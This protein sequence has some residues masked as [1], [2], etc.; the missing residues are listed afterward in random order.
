MKLFNWRLY[1][2][3]LMVAVLSA[4]AVPLQSDADLTGDAF[5][6]VG[7]FAF[8]FTSS[9]QDPY[10]AQGGFKWQDTG[11]LLKLD[12]NNPMGSI[13]A[14]IEITDSRSVVQRS[15]GSQEV[16]DS[17]EELLQKIWGY[18]VPVEGLR[19]W[20]QGKSMPGQELLSAKYDNDELTSFKQSGWQV[21]LSNYDEK[22]PKRINL[23]RESSQ[24]RM[25]LKFMVN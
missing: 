24:D 13:L 12:L 11:Q 3:F 6:R 5:K 20:I 19:Y 8:N 23:L 25:Q 1:L 7:R 21:K 2:S 22:G 18:S 9:L 17:P 4:C 10:A 14:R 15:D 16:A